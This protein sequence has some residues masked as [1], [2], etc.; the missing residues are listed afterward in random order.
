MRIL[1]LAD[2]HGNSK[3]IP[4]LAKA[5]KTCDAVVLAGD[6]TNFGGRENALSVLSRGW[7]KPSV[8][9]APISPENLSKLEITFL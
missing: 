4:A 3:D 1:A 2:I 6:I 8:S 7:T 5:A 9:R